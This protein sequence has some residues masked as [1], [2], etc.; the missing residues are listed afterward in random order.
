MT[1]PETPL[2]LDALAALDSMLAAGKGNPPGAPRP[3]EAAG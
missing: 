3:V 1:T 2:D